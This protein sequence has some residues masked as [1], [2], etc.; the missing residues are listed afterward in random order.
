MNYEEI[1]RKLRDPEGGPSREEA[2]DALEELIQLNGYLVKSLDAS[3]EDCDRRSAQAMEAA[4][5]CQ[6]LEMELERLADPQKIFAENDCLHNHCSA[7]EEELRIVR[8]QLEMVYL[9][10]GG[11]K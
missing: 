11:K 10:F 1:L 8:A 3:R 7:L 2:A 6:N 9:I 5:R 4:E